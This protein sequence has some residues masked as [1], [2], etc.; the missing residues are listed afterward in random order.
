MTPSGDMKRSTKVMSESFL[1]SNM[2]PQVGIGFNRHIWESLESAIRGWVQQRGKLTIITGPVFIPEEG[3]I[4]YQVIGDN[5]VAVPT[6]F[7]KIVVDAKNANE[8][9]VLAFIL[10]NEG[11]TGRQYSEF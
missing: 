2:A 8:V 1:L 3:Q 6:H 9:E 7:F 4:S 5:Y 10:P 11:L